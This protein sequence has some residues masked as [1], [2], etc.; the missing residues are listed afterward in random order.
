MLLTAHVAGAQPA[1]ACVAT[2]VD[3][4]RKQAQ[5]IIR[6]GSQASSKGPAEYFTGNVRVSPIFSAKPSTP[7]SGAY[8]TFAPGARSAWHTHPAGQHLIVT[9]GEGWIQ[10]WGGPVSELRE[11]DVVWC[12]PGVKHWHGASTKSKLTHIALTR[13]VNDK[14]VEWLEKVSD[15]Q[16]RR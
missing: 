7:L 12:P 4:S 11:G 16:Y 2:G 15:D 9:A 14:N 5:T 1:N 10:G 3:G 6:A 13:L 8:V